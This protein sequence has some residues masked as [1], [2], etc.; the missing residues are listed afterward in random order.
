MDDVYGIWRV[1]HNTRSIASC[2][3]VKFI[4]P[5][6]LQSVRQLTL[7]VTKSASG[8]VQHRATSNFVLLRNV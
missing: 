3:D 2:Q 8:G 7:T 4:M 5:L 6:E 1:I